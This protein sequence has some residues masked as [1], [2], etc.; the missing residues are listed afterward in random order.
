MPI[1][2]LLAGQWLDFKFMQ[3]ALSTHIPFYLCNILSFKAKRPYLFTLQVIRCWLL[4]LQ[5]SM[6]FVFY[7]ILLFADSSDKMFCGI[8]L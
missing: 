8:L 5:T 3:L 6:L 1:I 2:S 7:I 4:S